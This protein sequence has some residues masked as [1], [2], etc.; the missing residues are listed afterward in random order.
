M[1]N[2]KNDRKITIADIARDLNVSK[3]TVSRAISG[4][5]RI[6]ASTRELINRYIEEHNYKPNVIAKGLA[7]S[8]TFNIG[9]VL[10]GDY[11]LMDLPFFQKCMSG[12][13]EFAATMDYDVLISMV[14]TSDI[15]QLKRMIDN[16]KVDGVILTRTLIQ[17]GPA[18][19]LKSNDIP[20]VTIGSSSDEDIIQID[21]DHFSACKELTSIL[22]TMKVGKI[23]IIGGD[24]SYMVTRRRLDGFMEAYN[25]WDMQVDEEQIC[26]DCDNAL[27]IEK[28][29]DKLLSQ[30]TECILC[31]DDSI[32]TTVLG[33]LR[34]LGVSVPGDVR[35]ASFYNSSMLENNNPAITSLQ[36]DAKKIGEASCRVLLNMIENK[37]VESRTLLGYEV[38]LKESTKTS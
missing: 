1:E 16:H 34:K 25:V 8:K 11:N 14:S 27:A 2:S 4:K 12:V 22:L 28:A 13:C 19:Y 5:G 7:T 35:I 23:G 3:T 31:M 18:N 6:G 20:F 9:L 21:N 30:D 15:S 38:S 24:R 17:D 26:L 10:P 32:C 37:D 33:K 36:F 29:V